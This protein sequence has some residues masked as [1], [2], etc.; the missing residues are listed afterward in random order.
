MHHF[1]HCMAGNHTISM[2]CCVLLTSSTNAIAIL[3]APNIAES[4]VAGR[5][6]CE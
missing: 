1:C 2:Q 5:A 6:R 3:I 4:Y